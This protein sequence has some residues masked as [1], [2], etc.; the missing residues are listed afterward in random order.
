MTQQPIVAPEALMKPV[1]VTPQ[2]AVTTPTVATGAV[3]M[4]PAI[5]PVSKVTRILGSTQDANWYLSRELDLA[6]VTN[7]AS[8]MHFGIKSISVRPATA[9]QMAN[10]TIAN[11]TLDT[12]LGKI[13]GIQIKESR[14]EVGQ[15]YVQE[16]SRNIAKEGQP[17]NWMSD[18]KLERAVQ[19]QILSY[20]HD[21]LQPANA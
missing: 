19:A 3:G 21:M 11:V 9:G 5:P 17:A 6:N 1:V 10:Y 15:I 8:N 4:T 18:L 20:V 7:E 12:V 13:M 14:R 16:S 2:G